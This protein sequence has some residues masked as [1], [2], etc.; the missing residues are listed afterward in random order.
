MSSPSPPQQDGETQS[1]LRVCG[2]AENGFPLAR[3]AIF[4]LAGRD[5]EVE[6]ETDDSP[7]THAHFLWI[8][9]LGGQNRLAGG[10]QT[11]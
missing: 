7:E 4:G 5:A 8:L 10:I 1:C 11:Q 2:V 9:L 6:D 3:E